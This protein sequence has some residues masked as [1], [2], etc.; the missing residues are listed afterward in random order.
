MN[1]RRLVALFRKQR[2]ERE[3]EGEVLAH[4]ELAERDA[5]AAGLPPAEAR[6]A[7]RQRFGGIEQIKEDHRDQRSVRWME[8]LFRDVRYGIVSLGRAPAF[9][10]VVVAVLAIGIGANVAMFNVVDA[11]LLK[12]L[13]FPDPDRLVRVWEA[14]RPGI[15]NATMASEFL[16]W[17]R[18]G[19]CF[20]ALSAEQQISAAMNDGTQP[21][22]LAGK[23]VT[24]D[25]FRVFGVTAAMGRTLSPDDDASAI[26]ISHAAWQN[27][28]GGDPAILSRRLTID[29]APHQVI[30]VLKPGAFD[31]D[32]TLFW[33]PL[34]FTAQQLAVK[35][36]WLSVYG[37]LTTGLAPARE[38][39]AA[40]HAARAGAQEDRQSAIVIEPLAA[41]MVGKNF[42]RS[43]NVAFG[44]VLLVLLIACANVANLLLAKG[45]TRRRELAV[46]AALGAGK[47]RLLAQ[48]ATE[49]LVLCLLGGAAGVAMAALMLRL[50]SPLLAN[51][52]PFTADIM[53]DWRV[54]AFAA[55]IALAV[56]LLAGVLPAFQTSFGNLAAGLSRGVRGSSGR[57]AGVRRAIVIGEV[58]LSLVLVC[59]ALLL[60][61]SLL[62]LQSVATGIRIENVLTMSLD[63]PALAYPSPQKAALFY[64]N[65][66][67]HL[68]AVPGITQAG[69]STHLPLR[70]ISNAEGLRVPG[71]EKRITTRFKRVDPGYFAT[72]AIP[73]TA[74]RGISAQDT[75]G[76]PGVVVINQAL[77]ARLA[78]VAGMKDPIGKRIAVSSPGYLE[79]TDDWPEVEI[80]GIIRNEKVSSPGASD[81]PVT[82]AAL[83]QA[84]YTHLAIV[85]RTDSPTAAILPA[86]R[87]AVRDVDPALPLDD[88]ATM[89]Q[90]RGT[91]LA[92]TSGPAKLIGAFAAI[93]VLLAA[94]GLYGV[95]SQLVTQQRREIGIRMAL[96]ASSFDVLGRIL[97]NGL[98]M[99]VIGLAIGM[100]GAVAL[101]RVMK[102]LL[103]EVSPLDP[104]ALTLAGVC[105][106]VIGLVAG[107]LPA[108]R[109]AQVDPVHVL[110]DEG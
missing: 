102:S 13:P 92:G 70:W 20:A 68:R 53:L 95:L 36:H 5:L 17:K 15:F 3:L 56:A 2:L 26:V 21:T 78:D 52:I 46:R 84:P 75:H 32:K 69:L 18:L 97:R 12:P 96:G 6:L 10:A 55:L 59:G 86:I 73:V 90:V 62:N 43:L 79:P 94:I 85:I 64:Q 108:S 83:A 44:A 25:Y 107:Y 19:T 72:F 57:N 93:A 30:G 47:G 42:E 27:L 77:A 51:S 105:M 48:L 11:V 67:E 104:A 109:A 40:V 106:V 63:L 45:A 54:L 60:F 61:R 82:Y 71:V 89:E 16:E 38:Q 1:L 33:K 31:R 58:A 41:L 34:I 50:V 8:N 28:F 76:A 39:M 9:T 29:G 91:T 35:S 110:R 4:L 66:A 87:Q 65:L 22:R 98:T 103:F 24:G 100:A 80:V 81:P 99:L 14:P 101:T 7:A 49:S 23:A 37:R 88:I 74:G